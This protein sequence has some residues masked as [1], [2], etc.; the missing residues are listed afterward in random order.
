MEKSSSPFAFV[1]QLTGVPLPGLEIKGFGKLG[2]PLNE[3]Q[4]IVLF[5]SASQ[6]H[7]MKSEQQHFVEFDEQKLQI[8]N[9]QFEL[10]VVSPLLKTLQSSLDL[11]C[12]ITLNLS[13]FV[14]VEKRGAFTP[15][16][17]ASSWGSL[18]ICL[19][20]EFE[21]G[22]IQLKHEGRT[23]TFDFAVQSAFNYQYVAY[24]NQCTH[25]NSSV[26]R[27][28]QALL[29][30]DIH[31]K[32]SL[33]APISSSNS[34]VDEVIKTMVPCDE[35]KNPAAIFCINCN[36]FLCEKHNIHATMKSL[37]FHHLLAPNET[38][39]SSSSKCAVHPS[40]RTEY[41]CPKEQILLC[42]GKKIPTHSHSPIFQTV[43]FPKTAPTA[44]MNSSNSETSTK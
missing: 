29:I 10:Q 32:D 24:F 9:T 42:K 5:Q 44:P 3:P 28:Y 17:K 27:G 6:Q 37:S 21:G 38:S 18:V 25:S 16:K 30:Y 26:T 33:G 31:R 23:E 20:S 22:T 1:G 12:E 11:P 43:Y 36:V 2:L 14:L 19:P 40:E 4:A 39:F 7:S 41:Y 15:S 34:E 35:C 13:K 8:H